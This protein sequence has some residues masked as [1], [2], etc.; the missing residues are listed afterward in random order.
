MQYFEQVNLMRLFLR[1]ERL[2]DWELHLHAIR[3]M[4][5]HFHASA[6]LPYAKSAHLYVQQMEELSMKMNAEEYE[7]LTQKGFFTI[8]RSDKLWAG[9][10]SDMTIE[11]VLMRSLKSSGGLTHGRGVT[12]CTLA[13]WVLTLPLCM[14]VSNAIE[15]FCGETSTN[16]EQHVILR[17]SRQVRDEK[18]LHQLIEWLQAH[19]PFVNCRQTQ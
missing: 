17:D 2:G 18:D 4:L 5:P 7:Q 9:I 8:R 12:E 16:S 11:Q 19:S 10:W 14:H 15:S 1:A 3:K 6:H 13:R